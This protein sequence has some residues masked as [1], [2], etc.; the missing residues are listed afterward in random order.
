MADGEDLRVTSET[1]T[2]GE[3]RILTDYFLIES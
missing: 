1:A 3:L 2:G